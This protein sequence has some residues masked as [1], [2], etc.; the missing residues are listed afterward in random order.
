VARLLKDVI[1]NACLQRRHWQCAFTKMSLPVT[2][3]F[4]VTVSGALPFI[5]FKFTFITLIINNIIIII[6]IYKKKTE[7][8]VFTSV[9]FFSFQA[10][11][12]PV[13]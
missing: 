13:T 8:S 1:G 10:K 2:R 7:L 11:E 5:N 12:R 9:V 4:R 3:L 6:I